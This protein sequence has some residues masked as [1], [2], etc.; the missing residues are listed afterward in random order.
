MLV[1]PCCM[2]GSAACL[3]FSDADGVQDEH[4]EQASRDRSCMQQ[5]LKQQV[6]SMQQLHALG[7]QFS[8]ICMV[9]HQREKLIILVYINCTF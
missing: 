6:S 8:S 5:Q 1:M 3:G 2:K 9:K 4:L 7:F